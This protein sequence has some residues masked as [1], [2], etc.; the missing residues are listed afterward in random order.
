VRAQCKFGCP[1]RRFDGP[2]AACGI[3]LPGN[4]PAARRVEIEKFAAFY[5]LKAGAL[6]ARAHTRNIN[7]C[8]LFVFPARA[9]RYASAP[10]FVS[11]TQ[12]ECVRRL[13]GNGRMEIMC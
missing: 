1:A 6:V 11:A 10:A 7:A 13:C 8:N 9:L 5:Y 3:K 2:F 12:P 4:H